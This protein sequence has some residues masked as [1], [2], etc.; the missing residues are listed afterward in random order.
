[1]AD[2]NPDGGELSY[3]DGELMHENI[4]GK[5]ITDIDWVDDHLVLK[6]EGKAVPV[7]DLHVRVHK[8]SLLYMHVHP[9]T[10]PTLE[11]QG[12]LTVYDVLD[13]ISSRPQETR[14][15][16]AM[17]SLPQ[18]SPS[19]SRME[20]LPQDSPRSSAMETLSQVPVLCTECGHQWGEHISREPH[21]CI[22]KYCACRGYT[23]GART[24]G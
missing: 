22:V 18:E 24:D 15:S 12:Q 23:E 8:G 19:T 13:T 14:E 20:P 10:S 21:T 6:L 4:V 17:E 1:M 16:S 7:M 3:V 5:T 2:M 11:D 9:D